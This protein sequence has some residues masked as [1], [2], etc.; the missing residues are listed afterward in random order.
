MKQHK[1]RYRENKAYQASDIS[2]VQYQCNHCKLE[3]MIDL[4]VEMVVVYWRLFPTISKWTLVN[5]SGQY[6]DNERLMKYLLT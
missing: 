1:W 2:Q 4:N 6:C 5:E 3:A